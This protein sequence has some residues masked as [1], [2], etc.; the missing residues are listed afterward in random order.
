MRMS[1]DRG[2]VIDAGLLTSIN[3]ESLFASKG[4]PKRFN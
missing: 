4:N 3:D 1:S 2:L